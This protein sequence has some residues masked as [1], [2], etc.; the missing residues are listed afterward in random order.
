MVIGKSDF[1]AHGNRSDRD[2]SGFILTGDVAS[3]VIAP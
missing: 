2:G 3:H 1:D